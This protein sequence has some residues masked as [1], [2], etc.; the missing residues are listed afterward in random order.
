MMNTQLI[1]SLIQVVQS[2]PSVEQKIL[3]E[4]LNQL[5]IETP[6]D[7]SINEEID[8]EID[9]EMIDDE[10]WE[11]W[12]SLGDNAVSGKLKNTSI[13]HDRYLYTKD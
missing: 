13:N 1:T 11:M 5:L 9:E 2:L 4:Q 7:I 10:A 12:R 6:T 3:I 8:E